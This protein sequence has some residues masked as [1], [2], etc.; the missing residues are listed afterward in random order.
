MEKLITDSFLSNLRNR[1]A[2]GFSDEVLS[3]ARDCLL[4]YLGVS[5]AGATTLKEKEQRVINDSDD[6][7]G[8]HVIGISKTVD[9]NM[10]ALLNGISSHVIELDDGHR[11][12]MLHLGAPVISSLL[13]VAEKEKLLSK[14]FLYGIVAGYEVAIRLA[15]AIQP[16]HKLKGYHATG[17]C[18]TIGAAMAIATALHFD[19]EQMKSAFSAAITSAAGVLEMIEGDTELKP[20]NAGRAA[21]DGVMAAFI[22][23]AR[24]KA[25]ED[26]LGG[27]RGFLKVMTVEPKMKYL[28]EFDDDKMMIETIYMKPYAACRHCHPSIE[29]ALNIKKMEGFK[30]DEVKD[31]HVDTYKLAVAGHDHTDIKGANS[32]KMSIPYSLATALFTGKA[33]MDEFTAKYINDPKILSIT[34]KVSVGDIDELTSLCP[35]KRVAIVTV[36]TKSGKF[37]KRVEYPKGEPENPLSKQELNDKFR[38]LAMYGGLTKKECDEVIREIGKN[39]FNLATIMNIICK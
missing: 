30:L 24:F 10:A 6:R 13:A 12:G 32:A 26:A 33:G 37:I 25:P 38:G 39:D 1:I 16:G 35:Q 2:A 22:G 5:L 36:N 19:F 31:I 18:G 15:C 3:K 23:K 29:A 28:T 8:C 7:G 20:F 34:K 21:M 11:I 9:V 4:D 14:E 17:T 27:K